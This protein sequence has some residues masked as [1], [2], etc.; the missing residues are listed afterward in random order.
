QT[1]GRSHIH[2]DLRRHIVRMPLLILSFLVACGFSAALVRTGP[3]FPK[4]QTAAPHNLTKNTK[5]SVNDF[6]RD[7]GDVKTDKGGIV[8]EVRP[9][10]LERPR[11]RR[12]QDPEVQAKKI[13]DLMAKSLVEDLQKTGYKAER[14]MPGDAQPAS[15]ASVTGVFTEVDEGN[16]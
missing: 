2:G 3:P 4:H 6:E 9:G 7:T 1:T 10:I 11:K 13:V 12:E 16:R 5:I 15:G 14:L 8:G